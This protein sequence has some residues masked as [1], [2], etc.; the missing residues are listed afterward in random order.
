[1]GAEKRM[2]KKLLEREIETCM[3][4]MMIYKKKDTHDDTHV[5]S[6]YKTLGGP[7]KPFLYCM[8]SFSLIFL[9]LSK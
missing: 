3:L 1:M 4:T 8:T 9:P 2:L 6:L 5:F 7:L